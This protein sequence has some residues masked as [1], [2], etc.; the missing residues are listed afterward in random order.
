MA[1]GSKAACVEN[2][3]RTVSTL[4]GFR[5]NAPALIVAYTFC[6]RSDQ[7]LMLLS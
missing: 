6:R 7:G 4:H 5:L 2:H 3:A 1:I